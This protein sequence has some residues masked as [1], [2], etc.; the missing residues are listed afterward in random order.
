MLGRPNAA[1][2]VGYALERPARSDGRK[3]TPTSPG[4]AW[5]ITRDGSASR[6]AKRAAARQA[7]LLRA[8]GV[9]VDKNLQIDLERYLWEGLHWLEIDDIL[10]EG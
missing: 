6:T 5:S 3:N 7:E 1:R 10:G 2:A 4:S 9:Y 8:E